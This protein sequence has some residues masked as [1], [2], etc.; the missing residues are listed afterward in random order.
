MAMPGTVVGR[1][2]RTVAWTAEA[3]VP[4]L[5]GS[6]F[7]RGDGRGPGST[8]PPDGSGPGVE[9]ITAG[10]PGD[11]APGE[12]IPPDP[13]AA[14]AVGS[15]PAIHRILRGNLALLE[16]VVG[17]AAGPEPADRQRL[18]G[19][20]ESLLEAILGRALSKGLVD[21]PMDHPFWGAFSREQG[22]LLL[23]ALSSLGYHFDGLGGWLAGR[24]PGRRDLS[25]ALEY[26]RVD[27]IRLRAWPTAE[28]TERLLVD[29]AIAGGD[30]LDDVAPDLSLTE[31]ASALGRQSLQLAELWLHW[32]RVRPLLLAEGPP[33]SRGTAGQPEDR[34][35]R[36]RY[37]WS[38][39]D[40]P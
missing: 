11:G 14:W 18:Q 5:D 34:P 24:A 22:R 13:M 1:L 30:Y 33:G 15:G 40:E 4:G 39:G 12:A 20:L 16:L 28:E 9:I 37:A 17:E 6:P 38:A 35:N 36:G 29:V 31:V 21:P 26:A 32:E 10:D 27:P 8:Q 25:L 2:R 19:Q 23:E 3:L 7:A